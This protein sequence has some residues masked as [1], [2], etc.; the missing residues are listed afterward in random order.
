MSVASQLN[1]L[2]GPSSSAV[3]AVRY[4]SSAGAADF[5]HFQPA[6]MDL[7]FDLFP[8]SSLELDGPAGFWAVDSVRPESRASQP[9]GQQQQQ[10]QPVSRPPSQPNASTA[11]SASPGAAP[12]QPAHC[13]PLRAFSPSAAHAFS[14]PF[15]FSPL[16]ESQTPSALQQPSQPSPLANEPATVQLQQ[17]PEHHHH[18]H[19]QQ[20]PMVVA[21]SGRL[22]NLLTKGSSANEDSCQEGQADADKPIQTNRILKILLNQQDEDDYHSPEHGASKPGPM[23]ASPG[24]SGPVKPGHHEHKSSVGPGNN[25]LL[26]L[27]NEK[28]DDDD[29]ESRAGLKKRNELLTQLL[30]EP[31]DEKKLQDQV[32]ETALTN[33]PLSTLHRTGLASTDS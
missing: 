13:S 15:P 5:N 28:N 19:P 8:S 9:G 31:E 14:N 21:E 27:L 6:S 26:Q 1:G 4:P 30:K 25:M 11:A 20:Q 23:R 2:G 16:Q 10:Q 22:R 24:Q 7:E 32:R 33:L 29:D 17:E 18:A 12:V 3:A